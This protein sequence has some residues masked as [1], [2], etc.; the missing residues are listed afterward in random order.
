[1]CG[2]KARATIIP[3]LNS[4]TSQAQGK[5]Q[6]WICINLENMAGPFLMNHW[7]LLNR[8]KQELCPG[9]TEDCWETHASS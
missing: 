6:V 8:T 2:I 9:K 3:M 5:K 7:E 1:M 4:Y